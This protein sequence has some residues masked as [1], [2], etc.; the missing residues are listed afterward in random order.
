MANWDDEVAKRDAPPPPDVAPHRSRKNTRRWCRGKVSIEHII[1]EPT[2]KTWVYAVYG[3][4]DNRGA[5]HW[6]YWGKKPHWI[7]HHEVRCT[8]CGKIMKRYLVKNEC[9]DYIQ[10]PSV[11]RRDST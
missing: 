9:P 1:G 4:R 6:V 7:C 10:Q 3:Q 2:R 5:C 11:D 8:R